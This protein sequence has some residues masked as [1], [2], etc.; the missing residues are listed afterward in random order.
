MPALRSLMPGQRKTKTESDNVRGYG[1]CIHGLHASAM[2]KL[3][4]LRDFAENSISEGTP[5]HAFSITSYLSPV[6]CICCP[7]TFPE[8]KSTFLSHPFV[9]KPRSIL[10]PISVI[11]MT[12]SC[13]VASATPVYPRWRTRAG[14]GGKTICCSN[15]RKSHPSTQSS[16][17]TVAI[18]MKVKHDNRIASTKS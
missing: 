2:K 14:W 15:R 7:E 12:G 3:S 4:S 17:C 9:L 1:E 8:K 5:Q 16:R 10:S 13:Y 18:V 11:D 6:T